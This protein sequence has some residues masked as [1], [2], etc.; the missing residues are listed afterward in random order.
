V[1]ALIISALMRQRQAISENLRP[2]WATQSFR[3]AKDTQRN[4]IS[5]QPPPTKRKKK[6]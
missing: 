4:L 6:M 2:A 3:I 1:H 5:K